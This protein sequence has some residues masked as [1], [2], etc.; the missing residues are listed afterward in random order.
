MH[1]D[2]DTFGFDAVP[3]VFS[4]GGIF[5]SPTPLTPN[6]LVPLIDV[7][8]DATLKIYSAQPD[9]ADETHF[10]LVIE[11]DNKRY[12]YDGYLNADDSIRIMPRPNPATIPST[13]SH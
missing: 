3:N 6:H 13:Q 5:T 11:S 12:T 1:R 10:T 8:N 4:T 9:D 2:P 7:R